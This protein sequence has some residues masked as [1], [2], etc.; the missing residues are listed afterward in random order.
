MG[1]SSNEQLK[2]CTETIGRYLQIIFVSISIYR[3]KGTEAKR[4]QMKEK[5]VAHEFHCKLKSF[6]LEMIRMEAIH[7]EIAQT[8]QLI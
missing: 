5:G 2:E 6:S 8:R 3:L 7:T 1:W 4:G